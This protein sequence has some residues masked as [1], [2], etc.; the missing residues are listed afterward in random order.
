[1]KLLRGFLD[2]QHRHFTIGAPLE[3][4]YPLY[5]AIDT[6]LYTPG[7]VT[8]GAVH[9]RDGI[10]LKRTMVTVAMALGPC[11][12]MAMYNTGLQSLIA[13]Q[14]MGVTSLRVAWAAFS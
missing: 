9:V 8:K 10:D 14:Q 7:Q 3:K 2:Q 11:I 4:L 6:F 5:E 12:L 13:L 1:M